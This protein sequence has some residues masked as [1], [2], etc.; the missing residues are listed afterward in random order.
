MFMRSSR[1]HLMEAANKGSP[2]F[3]QQIAL[4]RLADWHLAKDYHGF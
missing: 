2:H 4:T 3:K 1:F